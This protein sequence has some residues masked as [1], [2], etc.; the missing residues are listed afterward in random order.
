MGPN[1]NRCLN[2]LAVLSR[3]CGRRVRVEVRLGSPDHGHD[4]VLGG[5]PELGLGVGREGEEG[6][7]GV[8]RLGQLP[9]GGGLHPEQHLGGQ[10]A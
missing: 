2:Y 8:A 6:G 4:T 1:F 5:L 7:Q 10:G 9:V 3:L